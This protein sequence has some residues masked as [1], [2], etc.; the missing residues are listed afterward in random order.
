MNKLWQN[1]F[2]VVAVVLGLAGCGNIVKMDMRSDKDL[3]VAIS[4]AS[5]PVVVRVYQLSDSTAFKS[6]AFHDLWKRDAETLGASLLSSKE[7]IMQPDSKESISLPLNEKTKFVAVF[8]MFR[9]TNTAK[10]SFIQPVSDGVIASSW[11]KLFPVSI[12]L[13]LTQNKIEIVN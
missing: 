6:A 2:V 12:S 3:N 11:H 9:N 5:L 7:I 13:R 8:A 4:G 1:S 10:W